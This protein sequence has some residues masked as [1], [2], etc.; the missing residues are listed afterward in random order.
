MKQLGEAMTTADEA[1]G[2]ALV[3]GITKG[4]NPTVLN[5]R[6]RTT[7]LVEH[8]RQHGEAHRFLDDDAEYGWYSRD[9]VGVPFIIASEPV[10]RT[11]KAP[12]GEEEVA[13]MNVRLYD[14]ATGRESEPKSV[15]FNGRWL[16]NKLKRMTANELVG[17]VVFTIARNT[18]KPLTPQ[19]VHPYMLA[20]YD[21]T[22]DAPPPDTF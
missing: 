12:W 15:T 14:W 18:T 7:M 17:S 13:Q 1:K 8:A 16:L 11:Q 3:E 10:W 21:P 6:E 4:V 19:G 20:A 5:I 2:A 22:R 9:L